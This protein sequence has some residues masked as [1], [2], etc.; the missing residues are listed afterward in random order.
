[1]Y[2]LKNNRG[3]TLVELMLVVII[4]GI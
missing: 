3:F 2:F 4:I 1:M